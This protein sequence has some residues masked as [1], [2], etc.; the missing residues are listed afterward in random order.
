MERNLNIDARFENIVLDYKVRVFYED[1]VL[2]AD[3]AEVFMDEHF[4]QWVKF[5]A[6]NG[7][8]A[9]HET[10]VRTDQIIIVRQLPE[11]DNVS[12]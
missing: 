2:Y 3:R 7:Y 9:G 6:K 12:N 1:Q 10:M 4:V 8:M 5:I 11:Q